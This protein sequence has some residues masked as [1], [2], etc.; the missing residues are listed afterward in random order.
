MSKLEN[1]LN[2]LP[3]HLLFFCF[4][5][6]VM[7]GDT[8]WCLQRSLQCVKY[9]IH[10]LSLPRCFFQMEARVIEQVQIRKAP[11]SISILSPIIFYAFTALENIISSKITWQIDLILPKCPEHRCIILWKGVETVSDIIHFIKSHDC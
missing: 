6:V 4:F 9:I 1:Y 3:Q 5:I 2:L 8:L 7:G 11:V 10:F